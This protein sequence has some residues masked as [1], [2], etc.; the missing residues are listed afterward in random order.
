MFAVHEY[1]ALNISRDFLWTDQWW[2]RIEKLNEA[3]L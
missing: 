2:S 3:Y 1:I